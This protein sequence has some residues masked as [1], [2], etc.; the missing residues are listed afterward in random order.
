MW[1]F[2]GLAVLVG[3]GVYGWF[4]YIEAQAAAREAEIWESIWEARQEMDE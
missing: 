4:A 3:V 2:M 1:A